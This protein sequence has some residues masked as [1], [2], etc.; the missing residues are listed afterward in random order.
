MLIIHLLVCLFLIFVVLIQS[1]KGAEMGAAFGGS[2]QTVFGSRGAATIFTKITTITAILF[3]LTSLSLAII[4]VKRNQGSI[5]TGTPAKQAPAKPFSDTK[6]GPL[7]EEPSAA[8][9]EEARGD[10]GQPEGPL[11]QN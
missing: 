10:A 4:S 7:K 6:Q 2:S 11:K 8:A 3:M 1:S 9:E 5:M